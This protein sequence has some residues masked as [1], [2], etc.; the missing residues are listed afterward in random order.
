MVDGKRLHGMSNKI[1]CNKTALVEGCF[2]FYW[3][4]NF[5]TNVW[6]L[7]RSSVV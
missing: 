2:I 3:I 1:S 7:Y 6:S 5:R 4:V